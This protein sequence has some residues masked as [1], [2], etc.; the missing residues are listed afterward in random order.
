MFVR[1]VMTS[2]KKT[3][4]NVEFNK[5]RFFNAVTF[6]HFFYFGENLSLWK[7]FHIF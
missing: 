7:F 5:P 1:A 6:V 2:Y 3:L 4:I